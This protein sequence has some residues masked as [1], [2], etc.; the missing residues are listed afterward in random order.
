MSNYMD[1][2]APDVV[3]PHDLGNRQDVPLKY[4]DTAIALYD[5]P[6]TQPSH[7]PLTIGDTVYILSKSETGWWD[8]VILHTS[9]ELIRGWFPHN[10][11]RSVNYVQPVLNKLKDNKEIDTITAANT[12]ANVLIPSFTSLL[13]KNLLDSEKNSPMNSTRKNSAVSFASSETSLAPDLKTIPNLH[14][15]Q[16]H[17][18]SNSILS[19]GSVDSRSYT[20]SAEAEKAAEDFSKCN[21]RPVIWLPRCTPDG[22]IIYYS[23]ELNLYCDSDLTYST[24]DP[25][26]STNFEIPLEEVMNETS[27]NTNIKDLAESFFNGRASTFNFGLRSSNAYSMNSQS[28]TGTSLTYH[29]FSQPLFTMNKLFYQHR[30]DLSR[31][32]EINNEFKNLLDLSFK[33]LRDNN[34]QLFSTQFT[35]LNKVLMQI[36]YAAR[37]I[38]KD[39]SETKYEDSIKRK[40]KRITT[41]FSQVYINGLLHLNVMHHSPDTTDGQLFSFEISRLNKSTSLATNSVSTSM[42]ST[43]STVRENELNSLDSSNQRLTLNSESFGSYM[44]QIE[45]EVYIIKK[46]TDSLIKVFIKLSK[47]KKIKYSD[48]DNSDVSEDEGE[49]RYD[50]MPQVHPRFLS[51]E[52]NG[53]NWCNPFFPSTNPV[54]NISGDELKNHHRSKQIIDNQSYQAIQGIIKEILKVHHEIMQLLKEENQHKYYNNSLKSERN[55]QILRLMYKYLHNT[56]SIMDYL[57][58][59]DFTLFCLIEMSKTDSEGPEILKKSKADNF[60]SSLTFAYPVVLEFFKLKQEFHDFISKIFMLAQSLTLEDPE[61]FKGLKDSDQIF[62]NKDVLKLPSEKA[63]I[64]LS[65]ILVEQL[66]EVNGNAISQNTDTRFSE[67]LSDGVRLCDTI[68]SVVLQLIDERD[69]ILNY[70]TR[71]MHEDFNVQLLIAERNNTISSDKTDEANTYYARQKN[72]KDTPW[73]LE[74]DEEYDL[75]FDIKGNVKG[76]TKEALICHLTHHDLFDSNFNTAF[77]LT[78]ATMMS[79]NEFINFLITRFN[80]EAPEG[81]SYDEYNTWISKK[82][83]TI[84]LRVLNVM[85]LLLEK[86]WAK[87][88]Y[89]EQVIRRWLAFVQTPPVQAYSIGKTLQSHLQDLLNNIQVCIERAPSIAEV[90]PPAPL[91]KGGFSLKKVKLLDIDYIELARQLTL[92]EFKLYSNIS[93]YACLAKVWGKKS[94]VIEDITSITEFIRFSN[95]LTNFVAYMILRKADVRKRV[96]L[97]RYFVQV[98]EKCRLYN[99]FS[100]MTAI[101][102]ALYSS[103]IHRLKKTW[104]FVTADI[105]AL[106][107]NMNKLMNSS[108]NFN[109]Y[110]DML[111]FVGSEPCIPFF[112]VFLSDL[113]FVYHGNPD[114]LMNRPKMLNF[115]KRSKTCEI[116][117][118]IDRFKI[119][120][121]NLLEVPEFQKFLKEWFEKC[122]T[123]D[124]QYQLSLAIEPREP[125]NPSTSSTLRS[126][127]QSITTRQL[128]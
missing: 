64:L 122:P 37:L 77:L 88:Y 23:P 14:S 108:R 61:V 18:V 15:A 117:Q 81:L 50:I 20:D 128:K 32:S 127:K 98:A 82:Q 111:K 84:R 67:Q 54:L 5:F 35:R 102:S 107:Q 89:N 71:V 41:A 9:G 30:E 60:N 97:I 24:F 73:Y 44:S 126:L 51:D 19:K 55:T 114:F 63:T 7:L 109:E 118:G 76:G 10:Y 45:Y 31:W 12:A 4:L 74:G 68:L 83:N 121:Y 78:F 101:I 25:S 105:L 80:I 38:Q 125:H 123:I 79:L 34:K 70:A 87:S 3:S 113:T 65:D 1:E 66:N 58:S 94:G 22:D 33:A 59:L 100:S 96:Q 69:S 86:H 28:S 85:K 75:L 16:N 8:G 48:Y 36:M 115:A 40:I 29:N 13:Q 2:I 62:I 119:S 95:Q 91:F 116:V 92:K 93:K 6:G 27:V 53:G 26:I 49:E 72:S 124:E 90:R 103:P 120:G 46:N 11:I 42:S 57:E 56:S 47:G 106:L 52:L 99:N 17:S 104:K 21:N 39:F 43:N 110:R 112:G